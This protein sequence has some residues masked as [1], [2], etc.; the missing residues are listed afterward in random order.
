MTDQ[1]VFYVLLLRKASGVLN[2]GFEYW[3]EQL[4]AVG[5]G[6]RPRPTRR[7]PAALG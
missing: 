2:D 7:L 4:P 1:R 3:A 5:D 6:D